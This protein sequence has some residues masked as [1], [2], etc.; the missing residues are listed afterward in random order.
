[1][2]LKNPEKK[3][4][5]Y[6]TITGDHVDLPAKDIPVCLAVVLCHV[7]GST[8][9]TATFNMFH[10]N[11][12]SLSCSVGLFSKSLPSLSITG[13]FLNNVSLKIM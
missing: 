8:G 5:C 9:V 1:M 12:H 6:V 13:P 10:L 11:L 2:R 3:G 4:V 7:A